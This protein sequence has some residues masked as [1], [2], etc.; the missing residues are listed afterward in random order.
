MPSF[1]FFVLGSISFVPFDNK[2]LLFLQNLSCFAYAD[3]R[4]LSRIRFVLTYLYRT[5]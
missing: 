2:A 3:S 4:V 1:E 5:F